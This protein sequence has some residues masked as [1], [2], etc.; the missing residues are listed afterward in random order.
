MTIVVTLYCLRNNAKK[1]FCACSIQTFFSP[2]YF[3]R[4]VES[5]DAK[6]AEMEGQVCTSKDQTGVF[7]HMYP[8]A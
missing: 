4:L 3:L 6:S 8:T 2:R 5:V 1:K 7:C